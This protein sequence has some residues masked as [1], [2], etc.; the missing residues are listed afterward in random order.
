[1]GD[2]NREDAAW[3][4]QGEGECSPGE[5]GLLQALEEGG[6]WLISLLIL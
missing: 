3:L 6:S 4:G 1:M 2:T 5:A